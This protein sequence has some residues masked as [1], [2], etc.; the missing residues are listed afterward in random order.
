[1]K[2]TPIHAVKRSVNRCPE[3]GQPCPREPKPRNSRIKLSALLSVVVSW[4]RGILESRRLPESGIQAVEQEATAGKEIWEPV[5]A[6]V[7]CGAGISRKAGSAQRVWRGGKSRFS[8]RFLRPL[9]FPNLSMA[10][11]SGYLLMFCPA[12]AHAQGGVPLWTNRY[13]APASGGEVALA[14]AV[15]SSGNV[16]ATGGSA[17]IKYPAACLPHLTNGYNGG[18]E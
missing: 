7:C 13:D 9:L 1:M 11:T 12:A 5:E 10:V 14:I 16:F 17:T 3:R 15:D 2:T 6:I 4:P 18:V 8:R